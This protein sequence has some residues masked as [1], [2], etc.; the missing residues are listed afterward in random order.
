MTQASILFPAFALVLLTFVVWLRMYYV[1]FS[2][3]RRHNIAIEDLTPFNRNLPRTIAV[4]GDN[5]RNLCEL[6]VLFYV[7]VGLILQLGA[8]D[9]SYVWLAWTY[10][11]L[12]YAHS[13]IHTGYNRISHRFTVYFLSSM[14]L[15]A[16]W[17]RL[18]WQVA[19]SAR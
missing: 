4:S 5:L 8:T 16:M 11:A 3:A 9:A 13:Y 19:H 2:E 18:A 7:A 10:V 1:R 17:L 14:V 15:W 12:R 6:P